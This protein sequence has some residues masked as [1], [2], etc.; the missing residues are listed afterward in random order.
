MPF[1]IQW[2]TI[3]PVRAYVIQDARIK[4]AGD[5]STSRKQGAQLRGGEGR[6]MG[7]QRMYPCIRFEGAQSR[8]I[9]VEL[10][11]RPACDRNL[12]KPEHAP[13]TMPMW[14]RMQRVSPKDEHEARRERP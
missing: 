6:H 14:Q 4:H 2:E 1:R 11:P 5:I 8:N 13:G 12:G 10:L 7:I 9:A 3:E